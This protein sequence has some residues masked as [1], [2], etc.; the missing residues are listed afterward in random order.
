M[1][2]RGQNTSQQKYAEGDEQGL[3]LCVKLLKL[4]R[5]KR[6]AWRDGFD[7]QNKQSEKE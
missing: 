2:D 5:R 4:R 1:V 7:Y 3:P 6:Q